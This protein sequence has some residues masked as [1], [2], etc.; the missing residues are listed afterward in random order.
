MALSISS[1]QSTASTISSSLR[2]VSAKTTAGLPWRPEK[3]AFTDRLFPQ[4]GMPV[5]RKPLGTIS[6]LTS[7]RSSNRCCRSK[8]PFLQAFEATSF[9]PVG[10]RREE[11]NDAAA[12]TSN[13]F[14]SSRKLATPPHPATGLRQTARCVRVLQEPTVPGEVS[15]K[16]VS[17]P[18]ATTGSRS[19]DPLFR[20]Y[21]PR[22]ANPRPS[23]TYR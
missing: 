18:H 7:S 6:E 4:P 8:S 22:D 15:R 14:S 11:F 5:S 2:Q 1:N 16:L 13:R 9:V 23:S 21:A 12:V 19:G 20:I 17:F 10:G 3:M